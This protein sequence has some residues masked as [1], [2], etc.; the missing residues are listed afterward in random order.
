MGI[1]NY[2]GVSSPSTRSQP[3]LPSIMD[4]T[5]FDFPRYLSMLPLFQDAEAAA[6]TCFAQD[7]SLSNVARGTE[8]F[9]VG[10]TC[11]E[12]HVTVSGQIKLFAISS[13]GQE[14]I[15]EIAGPGICFAEALMFTD[16]P[17]FMSAVALTDAVLLSVPKDRVLAEIDRD[18]RFC[19]RM[20]TGLSRRLHGL[21]NDVQANS[22]YSGVERVVRY[23]M[24]DLREGSICDSD[25]EQG[26]RVTL[27][28]SKA[29]IASRLSMTPEYFSRVLH[30]LE[31][32][33]L[34]V[35]D[36]RDIHIPDP[37]RLLS[38]SLP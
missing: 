38:Y 1:E 14:K 4:S 36:R 10:E 8:V 33:G 23:L 13:T 25:P 12:F 17:Y 15:I 35:M 20:L 22:L 19:L 2:N 37:D 6:L 34:I 30:E 11:R 26:Q 28:V 27:L 3:G 16:R 9:H 32:N 31:V 18:K 5:H 29:A 21:V 24:H 7:C